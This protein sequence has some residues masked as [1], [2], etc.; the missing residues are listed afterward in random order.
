MPPEE[1]LK[2]LARET[3]FDLVGIAP[4]L[5]PPRTQALHDWIAAGYH[6]TMEWITRNV[7]VRTDPRR[8]LDGAKS[9]LMVGVSYAS[10][11]PPAAIW[12][13]PMRGRIARYAWGR[14]YH[15]VI[16]KRLKQLARAAEDL[17]P[18]GTRFRPC[19]DSVPLMEH[20]HAVQAG[21]GFVG[22]HTL[23]IHP[24]FGSTLFLGALITT[25]ELK[26]DAPTPDDGVTFPMSDGTREASC[27]SCRRCLTI[28]PTHAFPA[29]RVLNGSRCISYLT[30]EHRGTIDESLRTGMGNWIFGCDACQEVC[31]WTKQYAK[32]GRASWYEPDPDRM[33]PKLEDLVGM[34]DEGF[35]ERFAGTPIMRTKRSGMLRN[36]AVALGNS[37]QEA[38]I[39]LLRELLKED[40][41]IT[42]HAEW[43]LRQLSK[44]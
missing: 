40:E 4:A 31:P 20:E 3:G 14:D 42:A 29:E 24:E 10:V 17:A 39:P 18:A 37:G 28:C 35:L 19:V 12:N 26:P 33:A 44:K 41:T 5:P 22:R 32:P 36:V 6:G 23:L 38:A 15:K 34:S 16:G 27:G 2:E 21:L 43:G 30:I 25:W 11:E 1:Q 13:D 8:L 7:D 9:I